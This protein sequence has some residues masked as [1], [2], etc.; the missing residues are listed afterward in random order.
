MKN[1]YENKVLVRQ[2]IKN[3][4]HLF[5][6]L[7]S[8]REEHI[9]NLRHGFEDN[10]EHTYSHIGKIFGISSTRVAQLYAKSC[11]KIVEYVTNNQI[12]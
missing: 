4:T 7:L 2:I 1:I 10:I 8:K 6:V 3:H 9:I 11:W 12:G 5:P